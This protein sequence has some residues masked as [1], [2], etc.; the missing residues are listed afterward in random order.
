M[1]IDCDAC[2]VRGPA[3][4]DC[5]VPVLLGA[6]PVQELPSVIDLDSSEQAAIAVLA[7]CGLVPPLRLVPLS[8]HRGPEVVVDDLADDGTL[9]PADDGTPSEVV[10]PAPQPLRATPGCADDP[11]HEAWSS[12]QAELTWDD[13]WFD[14]RHDSPHRRSGVLREEPADRPAS[15]RDRPGARRGSDHGQRRRDVS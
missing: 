3:C 5:V 11:V 10:V 2:A 8:V 14:L 7:R 15:V 1:L 13:D 6:P 12:A 9:D 4:G